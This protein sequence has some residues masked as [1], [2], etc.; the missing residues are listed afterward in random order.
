VK[1]F[2]VLRELSTL[3][4]VLPAKIPS[5]MKKLR[6]AILPLL[7]TPY[8]FPSHMLEQK[9]G[10][11]A[12]I[13]TYNDGPY[14]YADSTGKKLYISYITE[15]NGVKA[16]KTD[17]ISPSEKAGKLLTVNTD[18]PGK[19]FTVELKKNIS[20]EKADYKMPAKMLI[21]SD[22]EGNFAGF[23]KLLQ[24]NKVID[25]NLDWIFG[26]GHLVLAGDFV[27]RGHQVTE[28]LWLIYSLEEKAKKAGGYVH[29]VLGNHEIMNLS[30]DLRYLNAKYGEN[31]KLMNKHYVSLYGRDSEL[32]K[33]L[34]SKNI[35]EKIGDVV[36]MHAG[37]SA[38]VNRMD[39]DVK[40][41]NNVSRNF[42]DDSLYV[43]PDTKVDTLFGDF[44]PFW[45]RGYYIKPDSSIDS[46]IAESLRKFR[47][48][49]VV[50]G[51]TIVADTVSMWYGGKV[52][53]TDTH[54]EKNHSEALL[55]EEK[56]YYRVNAEGVKKLLR[57][58]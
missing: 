54:H 53:N 47:V 56:M 36:V 2:L 40:Q 35:M 32:G 6:F 38:Q 43:Y 51:H 12:P 42:Y 57:K 33:W 24:A 14:V 41:I 8:F 27:D 26:E 22:I 9:S 11:G 29:Y 44:G 39:L 15:E 25:A 17:S 49:H 52:F 5:T 21:L 28:V 34:R 58:D 18:E 31:A 4:E 7:F 37:I 30:G 48:S 50:T 13:P 19:T 23:R 10:P 3:G 16:V 1:I 55:I 20:E 46:Q 45:Y